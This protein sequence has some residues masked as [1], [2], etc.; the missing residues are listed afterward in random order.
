M[1]HNLSTYAVLAAALTLALPAMGQAKHKRVHK[2]AVDATDQST[3]SNAAPGP[4]WGAGYAYI[5][6]PTGP[7]NALSATYRIQP[8]LAIDGLLLGGTGSVYL[9]GTNASGGTVNDSISNFGIGAQARYSLLHPNQYLA[10]QGV[11]KLTFE[12]QTD[13]H[14]V[15]G[16]A[17]T[18]SGDL[19]SIF[20]GA[21]FEGFIPAWQ[22]V[23]IEV[24]SGF[25]I[26]LAGASVEVVVVH[27]LQ[28]GGELDDVDISLVT[29]RYA[30]ALLTSRQG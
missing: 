4:V 14:T 22:S 23:S 26:T 13:S 12:T 18:T 19:V 7:L 29:T 3:Q 8:D 28:R 5:I 30:E 2:Q 24:N 27:V 16:N 20:L 9:G 21:G 10:F 15:L 11:G 17:T 6:G 25:N 1:R